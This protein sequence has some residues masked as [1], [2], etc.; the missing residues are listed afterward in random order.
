MSSVLQ[1]IVLASI[2]Y[3][4]LATIHVFK[5]NQCVC[6]RDVCKDISPISVSV[7]TIS[8]RLRAHTTNTCV[9]YM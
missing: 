5:L 7:H 3:F 2:K 4:L 1:I 6:V 9:L 8:T